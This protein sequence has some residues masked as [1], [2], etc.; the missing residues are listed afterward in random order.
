MREKRK[1]WWREAGR[2]GQEIPNTLI[3]AEVVKIRAWCGIDGRRKGIKTTRGITN[4]Q[5]YFF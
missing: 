5:V 3:Y 4:Q 1:R 2:W